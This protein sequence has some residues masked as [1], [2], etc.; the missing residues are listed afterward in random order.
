MD[1]DYLKFG[2]LFLLFTSL[3]FYG[4]LAETSGGENK[5][6]INNSNGNTIPIGELLNVV[7]ANNQFAIEFYSKLK[8]EEGNLFFSPYS[9][10]TALAMTYEGAKGQTAE[11][12]ESV[13]HFP[14]DPE[15]RRTG[16]LGLYSLL[17]KENKSYE[18]STANALWAQKDFPFVEEYFD[19]IN[20]YYGG[21]VTNLDFKTKTEESRETI[22]SWVEEQTKDKIKDLI[23]NGLLSPDTRLVLTNA[24]YFKGKWVVPFEEENTEE[25]DFFVDPETTVKTEMMYL[26]GEGMNY[27]ETEGLQV[28]ELPYEGKEL[29]MVILLPEN[30][31]MEELESSLAT[32]ALS[33]WT[34]D[35]DSKDVEIYLP[36]FK[37]ETKYLL[38]DTF[39]EMGMP[40]AF[41]NSANFSGMSETKQLKITEVIHQAFVEVNEEGTEAAA[42]TAVI[43]EEVTAMIPEE[44]MLFNAD[45]PFIFL[46][47]EKESGTILFIGRVSDPTK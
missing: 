7:E 6:Q 39:K 34:A 29:S 19:I 43:M 27:F 13:F 37:F 5:D 46:I 16:Y 30:G 40:T 47:K 35:M 25:K 31:K 33:E 9:L 10:S 18:L 2:I 26:Y 3:F 12:M 15:K 32:D 36:K 11:E 23:P 44:P 14:K 42:A 4:C 38:K 20:Q 45:H 1:K 24:I 17:N 22:N 8:S 41:S 28:L 21:K